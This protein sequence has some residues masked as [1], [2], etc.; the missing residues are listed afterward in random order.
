MS[1]NRT[2][3]V[4]QPLLRLSLTGFSHYEYK[5]VFGS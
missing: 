3:F 2:Y 5:K 4:Q 1:V